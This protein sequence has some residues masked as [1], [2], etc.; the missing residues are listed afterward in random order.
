MSGKNVIKRTIAK[1]DQGTVNEDSC[2]GGKRLLAVSDGA[3]GGGVYADLWSAYLLKHLPLK[4]IRN[5]GELDAWLDGIWEVFYEAR[6]KE[7]KAVGGMVLQKFYEEGS[8]ATLAAVWYNGYECCWMAYGDSVVFHY[9]RKTGVL[10]HSFGRL[11]DFNRPPY[12]INCKDPLDE[13][14]FRA[15]VFHTDEGSVVFCTSD[16]LAHFVLGVYEAEHREVYR[17][18]LEEAM[19]AGS[20]NAVYARV[21]ADEQRDFGEVVRHLTYDSARDFEGYIR[22]LLKGKCIALDDYSCALKRW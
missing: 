12:L 5:F 9:N 2:R 17:E 15:G 14:G 22:E 18:E 11:A 20:R 6:E 1:P 16:A 7:A 19:N 4:P 10:E 8:F 21:L 3:G 13:R